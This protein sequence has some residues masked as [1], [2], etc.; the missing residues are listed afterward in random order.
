MKALRKYR[1]IARVSFSNAIAYR[2]STVSRFCFYTLF[3]YIFMSLWRAIYQEGNVHGYG[4]AQM[5]W[6]LVM[7]EFI[8]FSC[9]TGIFNSMNED[10]KSGAVAYQLGRP[11]HYVWY[12]FANTLG[13]VLLNM[14]CFGALACALGF[15]FVGPLP[16]FKLF[17]LL[18]LTLSV[19]L[20]LIINYF[21]LMLIGL[22]AFVLEDNFALFLI[23]QKLNFM[24][25]L[26]LPVEFLPD[27]LQP[28]AKSLPFPYI[29]W[30]PAKIMV[31]YSPE[32][33][34]ELVSRQVMWAIVAI[35]LTFTGYHLCIK[36]LQV[37][38]G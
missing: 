13:Q 28:V 19:A 38:G 32:I 14:V 1:I 25:G 27:W 24:L 17:T 33:F 34:L 37:N 26:F 5:V 6:Y 22:S 11:A 36:R 16:G 15:L 29:H 10:V 20:S 8:A 7:T 18:P 21:L 12:Q 4:Y 23:Y 35:A 9:G 31:G 30:A 3:I 2:A